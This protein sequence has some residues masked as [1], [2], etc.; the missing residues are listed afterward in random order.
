VHA[1]LFVFDSIDDDVAP[2]L[3]CGRLIVIILRLW[4]KLWPSNISCASGL[5][6][7][8]MEQFKVVGVHSGLI[9]GMGWNDAVM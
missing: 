2:A 4:H 5:E 8:K 7:I 3:S 9:D 1:H 6:R